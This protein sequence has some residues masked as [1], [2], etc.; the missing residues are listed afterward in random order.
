MVLLIVKKNK[1]KISRQQPI[2]VRPIMNDKQ[3][4]ICIVDDDELCRV[5]YSLA[6]IEAGF[7]PVE[8]ASGDDFLSAYA[9]GGRKLDL[10]L[11]DIEMSGLDG[12]E[13]CRRLQSSGY[14]DVPVIFISA[15]DDLDS[16]L[17]SY[18]A[19][20]SDFIAKP[21]LPEELLY[22]V[23]SALKTRSHLTELEQEKA[24][25]EEMS[26]LALTSVDEMGSIQKFLRGLLACRTLETLGGLVISSLAPYGC[27]SIVRLRAGQEVRTITA[28]GEATPLEHS[29]LDHASDMER[30]FQF[31]TR[32]VVNYTHLSI[33]VT[34]MPIADEALAGR[35]RDY[36]AV[37]ADAA[38]VAVESIAMRLEA[39]A[40]AREMQ[41]LAG[42][43]RES[44]DT[45]RSQ[46]LHQQKQT[47]QELDGMADGVENMYY[48]L[49]L[50][51]NQELL[52]SDI[53]RSSVARV[54]ELFDAGVQF[55]DQF[56][57]ILGELEKVGRIFAGGEKP[58][59]VQAEVWL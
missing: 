50:S 18:D 56:E 16:R 8:Y 30:L 27:N 29:I 46:Y 23:K 28:Y 35:I 21:F 40:R 22:K 25:A 48:K 5:V 37:V 58:D 43:S 41:T 10:L 1:D 14:V 31:S 57:H 55:D 42:I 38:D 4:E 39:V 15:H 17:A 32:M 59:L 13:V 24:A 45:L 12:H 20:G 9:N 53:V 51:Q 3:Y 2:K 47:R 11:L 19:G 44:L 49:G 33:L 6:L 54:V 34:N 52:I 26:T 7:S 36:A